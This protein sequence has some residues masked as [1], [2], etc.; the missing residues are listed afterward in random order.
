VQWSAATALAAVITYEWTNF[1]TAIGDAAATTG[2]RAATGMPTHTKAAGA[3]DGY[4]VPIADN[5]WARLRAK[6][7]VTAGGTTGLRG[8]AHHKGA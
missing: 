2:W 5:P 8:R 4:S 7:V 6:V 3:A 1:E